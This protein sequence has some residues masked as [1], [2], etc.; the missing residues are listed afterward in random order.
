MNWLSLRNNQLKWETSGGLPITLE[1]S[2]EYA[3][4]E[5]KQHR[6]MSTCKRLDLESLGS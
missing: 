5:L 2:R 6:K 3:S 4:N 1:E